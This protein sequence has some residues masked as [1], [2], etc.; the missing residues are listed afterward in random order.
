KSD[1]DDADGKSDKDDADGKSDKDDA[2]G[3]GSG[4]HDGNESSDDEPAFADGITAGGHPGPYKEANDGFIADFAEKNGRTLDTDHG[5]M[6]ADLVDHR[7]PISADPDTG[8]QISAELYKERTTGPD[9]ETDWPDTENNHPELA[10]VMKDGVY[11]H[12]DPEKGIPPF[13]DMAVDEFIKEYPGNLDRIGED[14]GKYFALVGKDGPDS[15]QKRSIHADSLYSPYSQFEFHPDRLPPGTRVETGIV[16]P[17]FD[18]PGGSRQV[19]LYTLDESGDQT[20]LSAQQLLE[21]PNP[22]LVRKTIK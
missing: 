19:R 14:R 16:Y 6:G 2:D 7:E 8:E 5:P 21:G 20:Y 9:G 17:W 15:F 18:S 1:K 22:V 10:D 13:Q 12:G 11:L 4:S 3:E